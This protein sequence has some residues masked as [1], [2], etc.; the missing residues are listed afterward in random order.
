MLTIGL[1][2]TYLF[3]VYAYWEELQRME[4]GED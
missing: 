2:A 1:L 4:K 3:I